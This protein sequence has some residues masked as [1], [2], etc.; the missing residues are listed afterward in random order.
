[1][2]HISTQFG[3]ELEP[4]WFTSMDRLFSSMTGIED[5]LNNITDLTEE[6]PKGQSSTIKQG[7]AYAN[8]SSQKEFFDNMQNDF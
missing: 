7:G 5:R 3:G 6:N 4:A 8:E 2:D 1:M